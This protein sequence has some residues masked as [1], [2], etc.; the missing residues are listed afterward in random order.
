MR[1][2]YFLGNARKRRAH[3][4]WV[5]DWPEADETGLYYVP[6]VFYGRRFD[7]SLASPDYAIQLGQ[8][9]VAAGTRAKQLDANRSKRPRRYFRYRT[10][11]GT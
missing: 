6:R 3:L 9:L 1:K 7:N 2:E 5:D 8:A 11:Q 10:K 4:V